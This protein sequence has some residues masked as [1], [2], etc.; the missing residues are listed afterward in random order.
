[1]ALFEIDKGKL[2]PAQFGRKVTTNIS[3]SI[4]SCVR[5]QILQVIDKSLL[6]IAWLRSEDVYRNLPSDMPHSADNKSV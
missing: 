5:N 2:I 4:L 3:E 6:P 1:M